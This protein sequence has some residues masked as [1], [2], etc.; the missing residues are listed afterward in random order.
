MADLVHH[1]YSRGV[2]LLAQP[3][4]THSQAHL[5]CEK[6]QP[7]IH[8]TDVYTA[9]VQP[10]PRLLHGAHVRFIPKDFNQLHRRQVVSRQRGALQQQTAVRA[11]T[12]VAQSL[13]LAHTY[14]PSNCRRG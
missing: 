10:R 5:L 2:D 9:V 11:A 7:Q 14:Q 3:D 13:R 1:Q 4:F 12:Q 6:Q 8:T